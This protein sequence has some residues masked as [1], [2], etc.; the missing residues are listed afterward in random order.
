ML[1]YCVRHGESTYN[2]EGRV[3][4]QSDVPLSEL[5]RRQGRAVADALA[6]VGL[7]AIYAS[8]LKRAY[9]TAEFLA[10]R[11]GLPIRVDARLK[12]VNA[13]VFQDRLR[14]EL[15]A[16]YPEIYARWVSGDPDFVIP[17]GE[18]RRQL[19]DRGEAAFRDIFRCGL[20]KVAV[21]AHGR[22]LVVTLK[23]L[24]GEHENAVPSALQNGSI[25][26][27]AYDPE[28]DHFSAVDVDRV[29][30]LEGVGLSGRGDL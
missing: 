16:L 20:N 1:I 3:Q 23:R 29:D 28:S 17:E 13:G 21:V 11:T 22:L 25:S 30:H 24:L 18:S 5:G 14:T 15:Q 2:A 12:E 9:E 27:F 4:G 7:E 8:P 19:A 26:V 6:D 10:Q